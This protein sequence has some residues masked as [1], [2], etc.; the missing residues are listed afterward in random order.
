MPMYTYKCPSCKAEFDSIE[1][2]GTEDTLCQSCGG[3]ASR[4]KRFQN[5][6]AA[7]NE[8]N[9]KLFPASKSWDLL[10]GRSAEKEWKH[11]LGNG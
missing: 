10:I 5:V 9:Y 6:N 7:T 3:V 2:I 11:R 8:Q 1:A 4:T